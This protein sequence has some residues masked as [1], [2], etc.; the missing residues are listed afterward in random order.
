MMHIRGSV[1]AFEAAK[2]SEP[3]RSQGLPG[4]WWILPSAV[5]GLAGW[6]GIFHL[7]GIL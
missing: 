3:S 1:D 6:V 7:L 5:M 4:G 2:L